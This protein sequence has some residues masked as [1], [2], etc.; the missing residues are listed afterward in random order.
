MDMVTSI[1][2][3]LPALQLTLVWVFSATVGAPACV[4]ATVVEVLQRLASVT[5][6]VYVPD[7]RL[8]ITAVVCALLHKYVNVPVPPLPAAVAVPLEVLH[9]AWV[10]LRFK[11]TTVGSVTI[12]LCVAVHRLASVTVTV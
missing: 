5:V 1:A 3:L 6:H 4:T 11:D 10:E 8:V 2:P 12:K 7:A 9:V